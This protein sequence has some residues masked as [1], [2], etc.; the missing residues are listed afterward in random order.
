[1]GMKSES[2]TWI[3]KQDPTYQNRSEDYTENV[4]KISKDVLNISQ[5]PMSPVK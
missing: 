5:S 4:S 2:V 1:M 3:F